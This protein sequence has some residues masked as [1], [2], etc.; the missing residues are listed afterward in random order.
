MHTQLIATQYNVAQE[1]QTASRHSTN[2]RFAFLDAQART[3]A[4]ASELDAA[5]L[6]KV[7]ELFELVCDT[8]NSIVYKNIRKNCATIKVANKNASVSITAL[9]YLMQWCE[10][11]A[12]TLQHNVRTHSISYVL[13]H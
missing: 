6:A 2:A 1:E 13:K 5:Q 4:H 12:V 9:R 3:R 11:N 7:N 10:R 8:Y